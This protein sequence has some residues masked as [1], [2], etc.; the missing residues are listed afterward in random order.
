MFEIGLENVTFTLGNKNSLNAM[1]SSVDNQKKEDETT[2]SDSTVEVFEV[3]V[4]S[5]TFKGEILKLWL[6]FAS[7]AKIVNNGD[8]NPFTRYDWHLLSCVVPLSIAWISSIDRMSFVYSNFQQGVRRRTL[9]M[10]TC[11]LFNALEFWFQQKDSKMLKPLLADSKQLF[12]IFSTLS[13]SIHE[14]PSIHVVNALRFSYKILFET[15]EK[16][17]VLLSKESLLPTTA[18]MEKVII[19]MLYQW[20]NILQASSIQQTSKTSKNQF[21][22]LFEEKTRQ[23]NLGRS[24]THHEMKSGSDSH[25]QTTR[26]EN[27]EFLVPD[28]NESEDR[29][30][31]RCENGIIEDNDNELC[32]VITRNTQNT[33]SDVKRRAKPQS[34]RTGFCSRIQLKSVYDR[35]MSFPVIRNVS[36]LCHGTCMCFVSSCRQMTR[37][38]YPRKTVGDQSQIELHF[39]NSS[40]QSNSCN[41]SVDCEQKY[42]FLDRE[43]SF[44]ESNR[45]KIP[46]ESQIP[47][48]E[49]EENLNERYSSYSNYGDKKD[50]YWWMVKQQNY[51]KVKDYSKHNV[52]YVNLHG[53]S[54]E[55][56][57]HSGQALDP[58]PIETNKHDDQIVQDQANEED[59]VKRNASETNVKNTLERETMKTFDALFVIFGLVNVCESDILDASSSSDLACFGSKVVASLMV[60]Q[61][62]V[63]IDEAEIEI[64]KNIFTQSKMTETFM[65]NFNSFWND[66]QLS[67]FTCEN[68]ILETLFMKKSSASSNEFV[69]NSVKDQEALSSSPDLNL[70]YLMNKV[71][72]ELDK[73]GP[74]ETYVNCENS[75]IMSCSLQVGQ[76]VQRINLPLLRL[77]HQF[78]EMYE[79]VIQTRFEMRSNRAYP[80]Q[81]LDSSDVLGQTSNVYSPTDTSSISSTIT[82]SSESNHVPGN[83]DFIVTIDKNEDLRTDQPPTALDQAEKCWKTVYFWLDKYKRN[84][85]QTYLTNYSLGNSPALNEELRSSSSINWKN[86]NF[87]N[88]DN[89]LVLHHKLICNRYPF[90]FVGSALVK[91]MSLVAMLS[92]LKLDGEL[93]NLSFNVIHNQMFKKNKVKPNQSMTNA[94]QM[95]N[96]HSISASIKLEKTQ[97]SL[98]EDS[99]LTMLQE[100]STSQ[101]R[102]PQQLV[103]KMSIGQSNLNLSHQSSAERHLKLTLEMLL[104]DSLDQ[105]SNK[106]ENASHHNSAK[107]SVGPIEIDIP[108]HPVALHGM[109]TRSGKQLSTALQELRSSRQPS[110]MSRQTTVNLNM[111]D[112][113]CPPSPFAFTSSMS[114]NEIVKNKLTPSPQVLV[115]TNRNENIPKPKFN[116]K[117]KVIDATNKEI[118]K[119]KQHS[120][121]K[122]QALLPFVI[123]FNVILES[124]TIKA[125]LLPSLRAQYRI[126]QITSSGF[127]GSKAKFEIEINHHS[128]Y[129]TTKIDAEAISDVNLPTEASVTLPRITISAEYLE[130]SVNRLVP[131]HLGT[132]SCNL[133]AFRNGNK[134]VMFRNGKYLDM[135]AEIGSF[136]HCLTTDLLNHLLF[137][138][139]VFMK[140]VNE[141]V[142]K[143]SRNESLILQDAI[144]N[145]DKPFNIDKFKSV[146][147][148][149]SS[150]AILFC[151]HLQMSGIQ[152]TATTPTNS[153]VRFET[154]KINIHLSNR[155]M[156]ISKRDYSTIKIMV[157]VELD[158][159]LS[160]GQLIRNSIFEE[161]EPDFQQFAYF[162]TQIKMRNA[163]HDEIHIDSSLLEDEEEFEK[164][165]VFITLNQPQVYIQP[166]ALDKAV[167]VW[168]NYRNAYEYWNEQRA[169][170]NTEVIRATQEVIDKVQP[171]TQSLSSSQSLGT[172]FLQL[173]VNDFGICLPLS[174]SMMGTFLNQ[175][176]NFEA[177]VKDALV[178]TLENTQISACSRSSL[179]SMAQFNNLCIRF[180]DDFETMLDD[181]KPNLNNP[182]IKNLCIVSE[183]T[184]EICSRTITSQSH[185]HNL[186][187]MKS[188]PD[189]NLNGRSSDCIADAK[190]ILNVSW[191]MEGFDIHVDT[192]I[193]KHISA[194]F[195]TMTA[196]AGDEDFDDDNDDEEQEDLASLHNIEYHNERKS[197]LFDRLENTN[198]KALFKTSFSVDE[199]DTKNDF[200]VDIEAKSKNLDQIE[201]NNMKKAESKGKKFCSSNFG[202]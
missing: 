62:T 109:M 141:V 60:K 45:N 54:N 20:K 47:L 85:I 197:S 167:L 11:L 172:L 29:N 18:E 16:F 2:L 95:K 189:M 81:D 187:K 97:I 76:V 24:N 140:E 89:I 6:H 185:I 186:E 57:I 119:F 121:S 15:N 158:F 12:R 127:T 80:K 38:V 42:G 7:P 170:L 180:A 83:S 79:N 176:R 199:V 61:L 144:K 123:D 124:F 166:L 40:V 8:S 118:A 66:A 110:R 3:P 98:F 87:L 196:I 126:D 58:T 188:K 120:S 69:L 111:S 68:L 48:G 46:K 179:V 28:F 201:S 31:L 59:N 155:V 44:G 148:N 162:K 103:V 128:L 169:N 149:S 88:D 150:Q 35:M 182:S 27:D 21:F 152:I 10:I 102:L 198:R 22:A 14:D 107:V 52:H 39:L 93:A 151:L 96:I 113:Q 115:N 183:G 134:N 72:Q 51:M 108:Q 160:L 173:V 74:D 178:L 37:F 13:K 184:Y 129:F 104:N 138:Q 200:I 9:S 32:S 137:V 30:N 147:D 117:R 73:I 142:Q 71:F 171:L 56:T 84:R 130:E 82:D 133:A 53:H 94:V 157:Q 67:A 105:S 92:G 154:G 181:W 25:R 99:L 125:S 5:S 64:T 4:R 194:L 190:W 146:S 131:S 26:S 159:N 75:M 191:K 132:F 100:P 23:F 202:F 19:F 161:A 163:L 122:Q 1:K 116:I 49:P 175:T 112:S 192:S 70:S 156:N 168:I 101:A 63:D 143:M 65:S 195:K 145:P 41:S 86:V 114:S 36:F 78:S 90:I 50:L 77:V 106:L 43:K 193:G 165:M 136:E 33:D 17:E 177:D 34:E 55:D 139:K 174:S 135:I 91:R 153:A 164:D